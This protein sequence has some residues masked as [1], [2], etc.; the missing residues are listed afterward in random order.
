[1][2]EER[3]VVASLSAGVVIMPAPAMRAL[4]YDPDMIVQFGSLISDVLKFALSRLVLLSGT[5][6]GV[7]SGCSLCTRPRS[8]CSN[9]RPLTASMLTTGISTIFVGVDQPSVKSEISVPIQP[10]VGLNRALQEDHREDVET[11]SVARPHP[12]RSSYA[13]RTPESISMSFNAAP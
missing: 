6:S 8:A 2:A 9:L 11:P 5:Y 3:L 4:I 10:A 7:T 13:G 1:M 12:V